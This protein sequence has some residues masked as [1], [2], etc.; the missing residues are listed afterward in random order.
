MPWPSLS[1]C[2]GRVAPPQRASAVLISVRLANKMAVR[3]R[4]GSPKEVTRQPRERTCTGMRDA[5]AAFQ[6]AFDL[7]CHPPRRGVF[8]A[9]APRQDLRACAGAARVR[10]ARGRR[11]AR[12]RR[13]PCVPSKGVEYHA[14][15]PRAHILS[16]PRAA[17]CAPPAADHGRAS[18][19]SERA[20]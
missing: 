17:R 18:C 4:Q 2:R 15:P 14:A 13:S 7:S 20:G 1:D 10:V 6:A 11:D 9:R 16:R 12:P 19:E 8:G 5:R 3:R